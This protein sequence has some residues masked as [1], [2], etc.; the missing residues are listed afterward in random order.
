MKLSKLPIFFFAVVAF[1]VKAQIAYTTQFDVPG[2]K[3][4]ILYEEAYTQ[5][6][7]VLCATRFEGVKKHP[8]WAPN[9]S[10]KYLNEMENESLGVVASL[11]DERYDF[12][13]VQTQSNKVVRNDLIM[14]LLANSDGLKIALAFE[15]GKLTVELAD[16]DGQ[17]SRGGHW[18]FPGFSPRK[19]KAQISGFKGGMFCQLY[20]PN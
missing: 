15:E 18:D 11:E 9:Y 1:N 3:F 14:S 10:L 12:Y 13:I 6:D 19:W 2:G 16:N 7:K 17:F 4:Q 8:D 5:A 20:K